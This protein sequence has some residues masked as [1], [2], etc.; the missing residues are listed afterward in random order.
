MV[1]KARLWRILT[2][3]QKLRLLKQKAAHK[4]FV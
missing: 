1:F 3:N 2:K 4:S